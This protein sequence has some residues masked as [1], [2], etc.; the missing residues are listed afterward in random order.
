[1][2]TSPAT[3]RSEQLL[4]RIAASYHRNR[5][6]LLATAAE[7][8][9]RWTQEDFGATPLLARWRGLLELAHGEATEI[10]AAGEVL[11]DSPRG[12]D[13]ALL[14]ARVLESVRR[15]SEFVEQI[16]VD[17]EF[18]ARAPLDVRFQRP[19]ALVNLLY[20]FIAALGLNAL[21]R[22]ALCHHAFRVV[23]EHCGCN[24]TDLA[25]RNVAA[26]RAG[27]PPRQDLATGNGN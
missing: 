16:W 8:E 9:A 6:A 1:M 4:E 20:D 24:L 18:V 2:R 13:A 26:V 14:R 15:P 25:R 21:D 7:V 3:T 12:G 23:E 5:P 27:G 10:A 11:I 19:R 22:M 17:D